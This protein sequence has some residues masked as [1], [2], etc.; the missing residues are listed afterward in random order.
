MQ[1]LT[2]ETGRSLEEID[3]IFAESHSIWD[4]VKVAK[5]LP[6]RA[7]TEFVEDDKTLDGSVTGQPNDGGSPKPAAEHLEEKRVATRDIEG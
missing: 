4:P 3:E 5:N 6:H 2:A 7:L 1:V